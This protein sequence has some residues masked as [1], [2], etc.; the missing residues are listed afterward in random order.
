MISPLLLRFLS[1][2]GIVG[3]RGDIAHQAELER[4]CGSV[5]KSWWESKGQW[6]EGEWDGWVG[7]R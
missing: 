2:I 4:A 3:K 1:V 7:K 5:G 6:A